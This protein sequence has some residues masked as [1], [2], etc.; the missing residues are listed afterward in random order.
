[1][2][3]KHHQNYDDD[4]TFKNATMSFC[5]IYGR[6]HFF[7]LVKD[8]RH[9]IAFSYV[10]QSTKT[11]LDNK[12]SEYAA[13]FGYIPFI[14]SKSYVVNTSELTDKYTVLMTKKV[15]RWRFQRL[16]QFHI[17]NVFSVI[18]YFGVTDCIGYSLHIYNECNCTD[19]RSLWW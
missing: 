18:P 9:E 17:Y 14:F 4:I 15:K 2:E 5:K 1:M 19:R 10:P 8:K 7:L 6:M 11:Y 3:L 12:T 16:E 13:L